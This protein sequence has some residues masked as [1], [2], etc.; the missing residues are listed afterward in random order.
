MKGSSNRRKIQR[1]RKPVA[2]RAFR[3]TFYKLSPGLESSIVRLAEKGTLSRA[4]QVAIENQ[5][6]HGVPVVWM[7]GEAIFK[8]YPDGHKERIASHQIKSH[9]LAQQR[10]FIQK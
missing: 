1:N 4:A 5:L 7:E 9:K 6:A 3:K 8:L 2:K 10:F